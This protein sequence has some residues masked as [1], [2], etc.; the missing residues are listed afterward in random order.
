MGIIGCGR[1]G[2]AFALRAK[3]LGMRVVIFD[4]YQPAGLDKALGIERV[5]RLE[6]LL[7]QAQFLSVH[8]PLTTET[9]HIVNDRTIGLLP[10][11]AYLGE[12][13]PRRL[14]RSRCA[15]C[16]AWTAGG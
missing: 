9:H 1:I 11:G 8:C 12:H 4:P 6:E 5:F 7:P 15:W 16:V 13:S 2:S 3:A 14:R 10:Q